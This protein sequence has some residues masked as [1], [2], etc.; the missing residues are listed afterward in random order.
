MLFFMCVKFREFSRRKF[1]FIFVGS[2]IGFSRIVPFNS[3]TSISESEI[4]YKGSS[5]AAAVVMSR[6]LVGSKSSTATYTR[7]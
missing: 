5:S 3:E 2:F 6:V 4:K 1:L 7:E